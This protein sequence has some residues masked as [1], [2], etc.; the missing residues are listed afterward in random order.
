MNTQSERQAEGEASTDPP[1]HLPTNS[2]LHSHHTDAYAHP[3]IF[4]P[5]EPPTI[6]ALSAMTEGRAARAAVAAAPACNRLE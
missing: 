6:S 3:P 1:T 2:T 5:P 4:K